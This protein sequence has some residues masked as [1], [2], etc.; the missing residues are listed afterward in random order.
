[1]RRCAAS[2]AVPLHGNFGIETLT[3]LCLLL[4]IFCPPHLPRGPSP[5]LRPRQQG[6]VLY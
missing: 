3:P 1:M 4:L 6:A 5:P 2:A